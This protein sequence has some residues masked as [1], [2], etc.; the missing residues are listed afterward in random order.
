M[1]ALGAYGA[2][3][4]AVTYVAKNMA[5]EEAK[6]EVRVNVVSPGAIFTDMLRAAFKDA[7]GTS[8]VT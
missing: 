5:L 6:H 8:E 7:S 3:K 2:S 4:A 1:E